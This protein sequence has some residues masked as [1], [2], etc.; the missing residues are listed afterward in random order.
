[1]TDGSRE[2]A[3]G[4]G[5]SGKVPAGIREGKA[6]Q[7]PPNQRALRMD[8]DTV[9]WLRMQACYCKAVGVRGLDC[10]P[11]QVRLVWQCTRMDRLTASL[12]GLMA[13][14]LSVLRS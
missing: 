13:K 6:S 7:V 4:E 5:C 8:W 9:I 1:M 3:E 11:L 2:E 12:G 10:R 14:A